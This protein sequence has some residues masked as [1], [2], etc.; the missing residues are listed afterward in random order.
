[1]LTAA[2]VLAV[3]A[4][5]LSAAHTKVRCD[6]LE[7]NSETYQLSIIIAMATE[8][9]FTDCNK[10][11]E[12]SL[13][14]LYFTTNENKILSATKKDEREQEL[15]TDG[16]GWSW[17]GACAPLQQ[18]NKHK[19]WIETSYHGVITENTDVVLLDPPLVALDK[20]API[21]YADNFHLSDFIQLQRI[22]ILVWHPCLRAL[23]L[24]VQCSCCT[25][26]VMQPVRILSK[27]QRILESMLSLLSLRRKKSSLLSDLADFVINSPVDG[28]GG[29]FLS[30]PPP[31][32]HDG[33]CCPGNGTK[34]LSG[35]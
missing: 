7:Q 8:Y 11:L 9:Y 6:Q 21:P 1:M 28:E 29:V 16:C 3:L 25:R 33:G 4:L 30:L 34:M 17:S 2:G 22:Q 23:W 32:V 20:D 14:L 10:N 15:I 19:P 31:E 27:L 5:G 24:R 26:Q 12:R 18:V 35:L 13:D